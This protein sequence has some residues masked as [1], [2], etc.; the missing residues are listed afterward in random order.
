M[1]DLTADQLRD[2]AR[3]AAAAGDNATARSLMQRIIQAEQQNAATAGL[4][5][6]SPTQAPG[7]VTANPAAVRELGQNANDLDQKIADGLQGAQSMTGFGFMENIDAG[8]L[9]GALGATPDGEYG[10]DLF[11]YGTPIGERYTALRDQTRD[12]YDAA[13]ERNPGPFTVGQ[14]AGAIVPLGAFNPVTPGAS[15]GRATATMAGLGAVE[16]GLQG[17][18]QGDAETWGGLASDAAWGAGFGGVFGGAA[19]PVV[20]GVRAVLD[21]AFGVV[22]ST[23][24][25][26]ASPSRAGRT[27]AR[28]MQRSGM[29]M[30][31]LAASLRAAQV[32]GQ[33]VFSAADA[34]GDP[35]QRTLAGVARSPGEGSKIIRDFL[36][37][38]QLGQVDRVGSFLNDALETPSTAAQRNLALT[39]ERRATGAANYGDARMQANPVDVT[40]ALGVIDDRLS[41]INVPGMGQA[42]APSPLDR[43]LQSFRARLAVPPANLPPGTT[44][45]ALSDFGRVFEVKREIDGAIGAATRAGDGYQVQMLTTLKNSLDD[46]LA[47]SSAPYTA[48]RDTYRAQSQVLDAIPTGA[49]AAGRRVRTDDALD[50]YRGLPTAPAG[51][52]IPAIPGNAMPPDA[53]AAFRAGYGDRLLSPIENARPGTNVVPDLL[54]DKNTA[55]LQE[56]ATDPAL[57]QRQLDRERTMFETRHMATGGSPTSNLLQDIDDVNSAG[58]NITEAVMSPRASI[59]KM[60]GTQAGNMLTGSDEKTRAL[61]ARALMQSDPQ[62]VQDALAPLLRGAMTAGRVDRVGEALLR[63]IGHQVLPPN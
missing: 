10:V 27:V 51:G 38:R 9:G 29:S 21:P 52:T 49:D 26:A 24:T 31:D 46:A 8:I 1:V 62:A 19:V 40:G 14:M 59:I 2:A 36:D 45:M 48:A 57:L 37:Q 16:G 23:V 25:G 12:R 3:R 15:L 11:N 17:A 13:Q 34:L 4:A 33:D 32:D 28:T 55:M 22:R 44:N 56:M 6:P 20:A 63:Q 39:A 54:T 41:Q 43:T 35:G 60:L 5:A 50:A 58:A 61:I 18:G 42:V 53:Q 7:G 30:D 47:Q